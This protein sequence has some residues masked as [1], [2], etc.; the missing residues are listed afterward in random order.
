MLTIFSSSREARE[1]SLSRRDNPPRP[2]HSVPIGH[3]Y[4]APVYPPPA[5]GPPNKGIGMYL[6]LSFLA[7]GTTSLV[8]NHYINRWR[9]HGSNRESGSSREHGHATSPTTSTDPN[10][11]NVHQLYPTYPYGPYQNQRRAVDH[12][13]SVDFLGE[14]HSNRGL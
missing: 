2:G 4:Q 11:P 3:P 6:L 10:N 7:G 13:K 14:P 5:G 1:Q 12:D 8:V 9:E